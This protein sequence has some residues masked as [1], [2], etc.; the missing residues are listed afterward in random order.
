MFMRRALYTI[1]LI[2]ALTIPVALTAG[3][4]GAASSPTARIAAA[5][6]YPGATV[7]AI[8]ISVRQ[9]AGRTF[10]ELAVPG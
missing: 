4:A 1:L 8:G 9:A 6:Q 2:T 5:G 3:T 10:R 7:S